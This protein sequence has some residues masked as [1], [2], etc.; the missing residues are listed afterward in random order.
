[1]WVYVVSDKLPWGSP[2][3]AVALSPTALVPVYVTLTERGP[4]ETLIVIKNFGVSPESCD[5][6]RT[7]VL[8]TLVNLEKLFTRLAGVHKYR[9]TVHEGLWHLLARYRFFVNIQGVD[10]EGNSL[11]YTVA[12]ATASLLLGVPLRKNTGVT[13]AVRVLLCSL[14]GINHLNHWRFT[15]LGLTPSPRS[16]LCL[17]DDSV[18]VC[19]EG[20]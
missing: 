9:L 11:G 16:L 20:G 3:F 12:L 17:A 1:V 8:A 18:R 13:G 5:A 10:V 19:F 14:F 2:G 4:S 15:T 6:I 7:G